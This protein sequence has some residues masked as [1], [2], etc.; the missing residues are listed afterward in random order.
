MDQNTDEER[1][2]SILSTRGYTTKIKGYMKI[3]SVACYRYG[4]RRIR[5]DKYQ[6]TLPIGKAL[7]NCIY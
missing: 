1:M 7:F 2:S 3:W 5:W 4:H 6:K